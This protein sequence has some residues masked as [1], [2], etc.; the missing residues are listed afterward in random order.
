[1]LGTGVDM[2]DLLESLTI[3]IKKVQAL[4]ADANTIPVTTATEL[5]KKNAKEVLATAK[6]LRR[7]V[8]INQASVMLVSL[9]N[10]VVIL[11]IVVVMSTIG[12]TKLLTSSTWTLPLMVVGT[13]TAN[14][15]AGRVLK[16]WVIKKALKIQTV[17]LEQKETLKELVYAAKKPLA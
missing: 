13:L 6:K 9:F 11:A 4:A 5:V 15:F 14:V 17:L 1:M 7:L 10:M 12:D 3:E 8:W 16:E 2:K